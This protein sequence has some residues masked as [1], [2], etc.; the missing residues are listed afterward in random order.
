MA[1][2]P[3]EFKAR[4]GGVNSSTAP[5]DKERAALVAAKKKGGG[6]LYALIGPDG[7]LNKL[8]ALEYLSVYDCEIDN[9]SGVGK[10]EASALKELVVGC[11]PISK[12]PSDLALL[13]GLTAFSADDCLLTYPS[14][15]QPI[16]NLNNLKELRLS[17]NS[18][19]GL[20]LD[21]L[22]SLSSLTLLNLD[23]NVIVALPDELPPM[24]NLSILSLRNNKIDKLPHTSE[25]KNLPSLSCLSISSNKLIALDVHGLFETCPSLTKLF[26]NKNCI[27]S[28]FSSSPDSQNGHILTNLGSLLNE[29]GDD[30]QE[31]I[32][33]ISN[34]PLTAS[35]IPSVPSDLVSY[36]GKVDPVREVL[37]REEDKGSR[38]VLVACG[39]IKRKSESKK[40]KSLGGEKEN[41]MEVEATN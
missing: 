6:S 20:L 40:R 39:I 23:S 35:A 10:L 15:P 17:G 28:R 8:K 19:S 37:C 3:A 4:S 22:K 36:F 11:N 5:N 30:E 7:H 18:I 21:D 24:P 25:F 13:E 27:T 32:V 33:N 12:I 34:N 41:L 38:C 2:R 29:R 9:L 31:V 26:A 16:C 1:R 14:I